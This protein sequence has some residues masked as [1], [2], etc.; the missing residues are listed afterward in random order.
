MHW[1]KANPFAFLLTVFWLVSLVACDPVASSHVQ[2]NVPEEDSFD[3]ILRRDLET[4]FRDLTGKDVSVEF[5]LLRKGPTQ[6]GVSY[7]KYYVYV[8]LYDGSAVADEGAVRVAAVDKA[9]FDVTHYLSKDEMRAHPEAMYA[10]FPQA[11]GDSINER[12]K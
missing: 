12:I 11:V 6:S 7:P 3:A 4:Y 2:A 8:K 9:R 5:E 1:K 10:V